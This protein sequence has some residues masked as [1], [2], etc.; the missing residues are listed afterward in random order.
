MAFGVVVHSV[1]AT[2]DIPNDREI[3]PSE[4][5]IVCLVDFYLYIAIQL[6]TF[7]MSIQ[8]TSSHRRAD[9]SSG[10]R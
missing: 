8:Y 10:P 3:H 6:L 7:I 1:L 2:A 4:P 9:S 5:E